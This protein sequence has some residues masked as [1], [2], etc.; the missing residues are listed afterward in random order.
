MLQG[1][2][3]QKKK[4]KKKRERESEGKKRKEKKIVVLGI[5]SG[6]LE[7]FWCWPLL[8]GFHLPQEI[9]PSLF[10]FYFFSTNRKETVHLE[11]ERKMEEKSL[12]TTHHSEK[13]DLQLPAI[14]DASKESAST[15]LFWWCQGQGCRE[16]M[17]KR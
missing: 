16:T 11:N 9:C 5:N 17:T 1:P 3:Q 8:L 2:H 12:P 6:H 14:N 10:I 13:Q 7:E 15:V 4:K